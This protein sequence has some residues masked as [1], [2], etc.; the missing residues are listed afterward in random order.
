MLEAEIPD[1]S[2]WNELST[3]EKA[4]RISPISNNLKWLYEVDGSTRKYPRF[5]ENTEEVVVLMRFVE[6]VIKTTFTHSTVI[7]AALF[8]D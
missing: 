4:D 3:D 1:A 7:D 5:S 2:I 6:E 8:G